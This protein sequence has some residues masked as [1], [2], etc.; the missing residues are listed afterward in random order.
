MSQCPPTARQDCQRNCVS[1]CANP[2][3]SQRPAFAGS[4]KF[5]LAFLQVLGRETVTEARTSLSRPAQTCRAVG[6]AGLGFASP[7]SGAGHHLTHESPRAPPLPTASCLP[8]I[9]PMS[10]AH[11]PERV[12]IHKTAGGQPT[13][14]D[15]TSDLGTGNELHASMDGSDLADL[16]EKPPYLTPARKGPWTSQTWSDM[17]QLQ[18]GCAQLRDLDVASRSTGGGPAGLRAIVP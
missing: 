9:P 11:P 4:V 5:R 1:A 2:R 10:L 6:Q 12:G 3:S 16:G 17:P 15:I 14:S 18:G 7:H 8:P 13:D